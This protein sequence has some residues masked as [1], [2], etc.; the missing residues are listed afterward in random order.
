MQAILHEETS[1]A[2]FQLWKKYFEVGD[3]SGK[4]LALRLKEMENKQL[5]IS[6]VYICDGPVVC[7]Q[8]QIYVVQFYS[9]LHKSECHVNEED[10]SN[11]FKGRIWI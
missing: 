10:M 9:N 3:K 11:F 4:M 1:F 5:S 6:A 7:D 2:L 8:K